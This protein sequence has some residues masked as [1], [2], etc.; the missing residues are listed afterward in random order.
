[1]L[2]QRGPLLHLSRRS[3]RTTRGGEWIVDCTPSA[4]RVIVGAR[5]R[6]SNKPERNVSYTHQYGI[7]L[8]CAQE[9]HFQAFL[10]ISKEKL[11]YKK[12]YNKS[13]PKK[14]SSSPGR[15]KVFS[16]LSSSAALCLSFCPLKKECSVKTQRPCPYIPP[17]CRAW[18]F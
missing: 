3:G 2:W 11:C 8:L 6:A 1:M 9:V 4:S 17:E 14:N 5:I 7:V 10:L 12:S 18:K 13:S 16:W 15:A